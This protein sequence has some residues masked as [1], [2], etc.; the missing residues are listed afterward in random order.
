L[1]PV[2]K[3]LAE[4]TGSPMSLTMR[5]FLRVEIE[6]KEEKEYANGK[7]RQAEVDKGGKWRCNGG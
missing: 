6:V 5:H 2:E 1:Q 4:L 3:L 7:R